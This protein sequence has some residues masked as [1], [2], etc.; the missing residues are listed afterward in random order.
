[1]YQAEGWAE[2]REKPA[3]PGPN[4]LYYY[5]SNSGPFSTVAEAKAWAEGAWGPISWDGAVKQF[6]MRQLGRM[7]LAKTH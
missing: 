4:G 3:A 6:I 1:M 2:K 5:V 7:G